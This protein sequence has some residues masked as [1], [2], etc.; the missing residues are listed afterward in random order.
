[1]K[2]QLTP[3]STKLRTGVLLTGALLCSA[4]S[5]QAQTVILDNTINGT[6]P[7]TTSLGSIIAPPIFLDTGQ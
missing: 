5:A 2:V 1:M 3:A 4:L 7:I 6:N